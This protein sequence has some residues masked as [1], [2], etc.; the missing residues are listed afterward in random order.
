MYTHILFPTDGSAGSQKAEDHVLALAGKFGSRV[1][2]L[3]VYELMELIPVFEN[4][5]AHLEE[6]E[7]YLKDQS[8]Q[9]AETVLTR[10]G[11]H[12]IQAEA[13]CLKGDPGRSIVN[14]SEDLSCDL[15]VMGSRQAGSVQRLLLGSVSNYVLHHSSCPVLMIPSQHH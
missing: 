5:Y 3:N 11:Q 15:L 1:T 6:L 4:T 9:I 12:G 2:V 8:R 13:L 7:V 14:A 10:F